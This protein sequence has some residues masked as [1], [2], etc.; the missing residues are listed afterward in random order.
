MWRQV[1]Y[2]RPVLL[3]RAIVEHQ[4]LGG[5]ALLPRSECAGIRHLDIRELGLPLRGRQEYLAVARKAIEVLDIQVRRYTN[6][7]A[8]VG[9]EAGN[10]LAIAVV[11]NLRRGQRKVCHAYCTA[12]NDP[13]AVRDKLCLS[14]VLSDRAVDLNAIADG[15]IDQGEV[16]V[17]NENTLGCLWVRIGRFGLQEESADAVQFIAVVVLEISADDTAYCHN[18]AG[19]RTDFAVALDC[20]NSRGAIA[21]PAQAENTGCVSPPPLPQPDNSRAMAMMWRIGA[22]SEPA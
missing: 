8:L 20:V 9:F 4:A 11:S 16:A 13:D 21:G 5:K 17:K 1:A 7:H 15:N 12:A 3:K 6:T 18:F 2:R 14:E 19:Q 22:I 10:R